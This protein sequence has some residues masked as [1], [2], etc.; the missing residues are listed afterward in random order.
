MRWDSVVV[1]GAGWRRVPTRQAVAALYGWACERL[2]H[3]LAGQYDIAAWLV[4]AGRWQRWQ[5]MAWDAVR[6]PRVLELGSGTGRLLADGQAKG[7][8][9]VGLDASPEMVA[10]TWRRYGS[11]VI[12]VRGD[13]RQ[14]PFADS[15]FDTVVATFPAGYVL[16]DATLGEARRVLA[17]AGRLVLLGLW[18]H[19]D[20]GGAEKLA[21]VFYDKPGQDALDRLQV[22]VA[23]AGFAVT[24][25]AWRDG[26]VTVGG[27]VA[28]VR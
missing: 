4:S 1:N 21:S 25:R 23:Q 7:L 27:L 14:L 17:S 19:V 22:K 20:L 5:R 8:E 11:G 26:R 16:G 24:L 10:L 12:C 18:A 13:G 15:A 3:E 2:Y 9:M 6:G 28:E